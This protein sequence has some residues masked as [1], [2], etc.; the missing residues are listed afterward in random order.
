MQTIT[1]FLIVLIFLG[2]SSQLTAQ[3]TETEKNNAAKIELLKKSK[4]DIEKEEKEALKK[5]V[6]KINSQLDKGDITVAQAETL[7]KEA[8]QK[9]A[10]NIENRIAIVDSKIAL[11]ERN[12]NGESETTDVA[13]IEVSMSGVEIGSGNKPKKY[14]KRTSSDLVFAIGFN[15]ADIEGQSL[16]DSPYEIGGS[17]FEEL[18]WAW[19]TRLLKNSNAIRLKYGFS[20]QWNKLDIKDR[21]YYVNNGDQVELVPFPGDVYVKKSKFRMTNLVF[22]LHFE[23]G[24]S[25]KI[26]RKDYIRY[27]TRKQFKIGIGGYTGFKLQSMMKVKFEDNGHDGK[28]KDK[29]GL[30]TNDFIYGLSGYIAWGSIGVYAKYDLQPIFNNQAI[31]QNMFSVGFRFD[32]D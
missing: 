17:G 5:E 12:Y 19:K 1:K 16:N 15:N 4:A 22:P 23:F 7:K 3:E 2:A 21:T 6:E 32:M 31:D 11:L 14:D 9:H 18:G 20:F 13:F 28:Y 26:E 24:P 29:N 30:N 10:L 25:K 27:T 8:A